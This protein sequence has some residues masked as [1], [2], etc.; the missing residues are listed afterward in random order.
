MLAKLSIFEHTCQARGQVREPRKSHKFEPKPQGNPTKHSGFEESLSHNGLNSFATWVAILIPVSEKTEPN[1]RSLGWGNCKREECSE[2]DIRCKFTNLYNVITRRQTSLWLRGSVFEFISHGDP[3]SCEELEWEK[4]NLI[5]NS[6]LKLLEQL[7]HY[8]P[9]REKGLKRTGIYELVAGVY[10][11]LWV[12][13]PSL[14]FPYFLGG[15]SGTSFEH[16]PYGWYEPEP[17]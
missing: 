15:L 14:P 7:S 1:A 12:S 10:G 16:V 6:R 4:T 11:I 3:L 8:A 5:M 13:S 2:I 9:F 17:L